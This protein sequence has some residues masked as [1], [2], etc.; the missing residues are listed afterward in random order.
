MIAPYK[1]IYYELTPYYERFGNLVLYP[2]QEV[3]YYIT[4]II[5]PGIEAW[6][7]A[8]SNRMHIY[9][10]KMQNFVP[11]SLN[12]NYPSVNL[13]NASRGKVITYLIHRLY[14]LVF[15]YFPGCEKFE[16]NHIDGNKFN[17]DPSNLEWMTHKDNMNHAFR[18]LIENKLTDQDIMS[19]I[20]MYNSRIPIRDIAFKYN[21]ST[22]YVSDIVQG[23]S[24]RED[25]NRLKSIKSVC[26][27]TREKMVKVLTDNLLIEIANRYSNG[28]EYF[29]LAD[30]YNLDRSYLTKAIKEY[31]KSHPEIKL[32]QLKKFTPEIAEQACAIFERDA[33]L[34]KKQSYYYYLEEL[35]LEINESNRKAL[36]NLYNG[37]TYTQISSKYN[38]R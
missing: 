8:I 28:E 24:N 16:V 31:A 32:H 18:Y 33:L 21:I 37:K 17:C 19:I 34:N 6:R 35:G 7:Y 20:Q 1:S 22:A 36:S 5:I 9:D 2:G 26:P 23:K 10:Y 3:Y 11:I 30:E 14:M 27:V 38:Y 12:T 15:C 25:S 29:E 13:Y 4:E